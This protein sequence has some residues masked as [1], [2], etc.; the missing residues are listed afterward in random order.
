MAIHYFR[1][2]I[3]DLQ[4]AFIAMDNKTAKA[5]RQSTG[6]NTKPVNGHNGTGK[7]K[8]AKYIR[9]DTLKVKVYAYQNPEP[10]QRVDQSATWYKEH[11]IVETGQHWVIVLTN[12]YRVK[13][14]VQVYTFHGIPNNEK[15]LQALFDYIRRNPKRDYTGW[16]HH[17][18]VYWQVTKLFRNQVPLNYFL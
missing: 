11:K 13:Y 1:N 18:N 4:R 3:A 6:R 10:L 14:G 16:L 9:H 15:K 5:Q 17:A 12:G 2:R 8:K 7:G